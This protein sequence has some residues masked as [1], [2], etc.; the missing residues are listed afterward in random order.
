MRPNRGALS[1]ALLLGS[2]NAACVNFRPPPAPL[3]AS[4]AGDAP[5]PV[6]TVR[7][8]RRLTGKVEVWGNTL[9]AG[10]VDRKVYAVDLRSGDVR[11]SARLS[12]MLVGGV[13]LSG[14]TIFVASSRPD[15]R[16]HALHRANGKKIWR[17]PS[18]PVGAPL[19]MIDGVLVAE[20]QRGEVLGLE[21]ST[22][23]VR[24][25]RRIGTARGP[26]TAAG[27]GGL[28]I[29]TTDSL[30]RLSVA[31]GRIT[32]RVASPGT[33]LASWLAHAGGLVAGTSDSQVVS[34]RPT[35]LRR[36]WATAVDAPVLGSPA[37]M[38]DTLFLVTRVGTVYRIDP[39]SEPKAVLIA[40]LGW[41]VTAPATVV[42]GQ[43][44]L[45][46]ADGTIRALRSDG[47]EIWRVRVW[48][49]VELGPIPLADGLLAI[50]GNGDLHRYR[51]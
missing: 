50:G 37:V 25:R 3:A 36:N 1:L 45:G 10:G 40:R 46:G 5:T 24:W 32:H 6:W 4:A 12:G 18:P 51:R 31:D 20:T 26:A 9:Y 39:G 16:I 33:V 34:I 8:G 7:A 49:P 23:R 29:S 44:L 27:G 28:L 14:D 19:A 30:F 47:S 2:V 48:R 41:P 21:P 11:W 13:L 22:G 15:G 38:G 42:G 43:I 35:D 17:V